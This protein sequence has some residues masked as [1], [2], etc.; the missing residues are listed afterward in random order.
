VD[1]EH[2]KNNQLQT[3]FK[4]LEAKFKR[5]G[6]ES[7]TQASVIKEQEEIIRT[8]REGLAAEKSL[9]VEKKKKW[10]GRIAELLD[11]IER[12]KES[13][14][15]LDN[16]VTNYEQIT[17]NQDVMLTEEKEK[18][19]IVE[20]NLSILKSQLDEAKKEAF[21]YQEKTQAQETELAELSVRL[22]YEARGASEMKA[23][24]DQLKAELVEKDKALDQLRKEGK[25]KR[26]K[27]ITTKDAEIA[28]LAQD[29]L[30]IKST[31]SKAEGRGVELETALDDINY[32]FEDTLRQL[33]IAEIKLT[34][35]VKEK[36]LVVELKS[37]L[38]ERDREIQQKRE[39][40]NVER[41]YPE[42]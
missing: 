25:T 37:V 14:M 8:L 29:N 1:Q 9:L 24:I 6:E 42:T 40:I 27:L 35:L 23:T 12:R 13:V 5:L 10:K 21:A 34:E 2:A 15:S 22:Q 33:N 4:L 20:S 26:E 3:E 31:L 7:T 11:E 16:K 28:R 19:L 38:A 17:V 41:H 32:K 18:I 39:I 30:D 36:E